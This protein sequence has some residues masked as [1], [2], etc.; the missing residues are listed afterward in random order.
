MPRYSLYPF[1]LLPPLLSLILSLFFLC[2]CA[3]VDECLSSPC[4]P[5]AECTNTPG[6]FTCNC[7]SGFIGTGLR[8]KGTWL[9]SSSF[10]YVASLSYA[11]LCHLLISPADVNECI[12]QHGGC[13]HDAYCNN[14][15]GNRTCT[16]HEGY[17]G[18]GIRCRRMN[19]TLAYPLPS[20]LP[21]SPLPSSLSCPLPRY[22][23]I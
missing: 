2:K 11:A 20:P 15:I 19:L 4:D 12:I 6:S 17:T 10:H 7:T 16:C 5:Y 14:T 9:F 13:S 1:P 18:D 3:D 22:L 8:C 21:L 23:S